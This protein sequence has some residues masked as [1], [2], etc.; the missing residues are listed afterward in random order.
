MEITNVTTGKEIFTAKTDN[1][2]V[3]C[4]R[5]SQGVFFTGQVFEKAFTAANAA[6][7]LKKELGA[8]QLRE[9]SSPSEAKETVKFEKAKE[10]EVKE[11]NSSPVKP[12]NISL[13]GKL[14]TLDE[15]MEMPVFSFQEIWVIKHYEDYVSDA[16]NTQK[17]S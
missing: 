4:F 12:K 9:V 13:L 8:G 1:G 7:K 14:Y 17:S 5:V 3:G 16:M 6:R 10:P 2:F 15:T 11:E